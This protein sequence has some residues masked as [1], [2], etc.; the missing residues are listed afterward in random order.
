MVTNF[1]YFKEYFVNYD[2][3]FILNL[4]LI[5]E[6]DIGNKVKIFVTL[7]I[8]SHISKLF[9]FLKCTSY[10]PIIIILSISN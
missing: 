7:L 4:F 9:F 5:N 2:I 6:K 8:L 1:F 3:Y 10:Q